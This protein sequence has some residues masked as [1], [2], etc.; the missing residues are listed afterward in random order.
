MGDCDSAHN[1]LRALV[2]ELR[3][4]CRAEYGRAIKLYVSCSTRVNDEKAGLWKNSYHLVLKDLVFQNNH[5][6]AMK[7]F[8]AAICKRL[9]GDE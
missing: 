5:G 1:K 4:Y 7:A 3:A 9:S 8:W 2:A 6:G